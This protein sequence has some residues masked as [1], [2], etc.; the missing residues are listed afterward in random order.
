MSVR[1][2]RHVLDSANTVIINKEAEHLVRLAQRMQK[3]PQSESI[4][5]EYIKERR[6]IFCD[7]KRIFFDHEEVQIATGRYLRG[8]KLLP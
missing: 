1:A 7:P 5:G 8:V 2:E 4:R 6:R 3:F